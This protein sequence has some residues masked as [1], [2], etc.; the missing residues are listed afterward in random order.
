MKALL[1]WLESNR[2][3]GDAVDLTATS[4]TEV[5]AAI[6]GNPGLRVRA[7][8]R[9]ERAVLSYS[10]DIVFLNSFREMQLYWTIAS[11]SPGTFNATDRSKRRSTPK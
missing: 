2:Y 9:G 11:A 7:G 4:T 3:S 5:E 6:G 10:G 1:L 8:R